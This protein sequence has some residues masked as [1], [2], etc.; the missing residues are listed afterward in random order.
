M[1]VFLEKVVALRLVGGLGSQL[2]KYCF[3]YAIAQHFGSSLALDL[4]WYGSRGKNEVGRDKR[5]Y[6]LDRF[7]IAAT[8]TVPPFLKGLGYLQATTIR[9][10]KRQRQIG[11]AGD[12]MET[13]SKL[14]SRLGAVHFD[15]RDGKKWQEVQPWL[16]NP[17]RYISGE[18]GVDFSA[19]GHLR[20]ELVEHLN[21]VAPL[22]SLAQ[23]FLHEIENPNSI[24]VHVRRGDYLRGTYFTVQRTQYYLAAILELTKDLTSP[25]VYFFSD[26]PSWCE[27]VLGSQLEVESTTVE[28]L[29]TL[30]DFH[31]LS[32][33]RSLVISNSGFSAMAAWLSPTEPRVIAPTSWF[34]DRRINEIQLNALPQ[35]WALI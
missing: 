8:T 12:H 21:P 14:F 34:S 6:L 19:F 11:G 7:S 30:E 18:F 10:F 15:F 22:S 4:T 5:E 35:N 23:T 24:A 29:T 13:L 27:Q 33:A 20:T 17:V 28:S 16:A 3:G 9:H 32:K 31:L 26:D 1:G 2:H 25:H